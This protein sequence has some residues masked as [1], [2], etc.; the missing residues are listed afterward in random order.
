VAAQSK[1]SSEFVEKLATIN[2]PAIIRGEP[3]DQRATFAKGYDSSES[4]R[5]D[6]AVKEAIKR[7]EE[8]WLEL[9]DH[10]EDDRYCKTVGSDA[11]YPRNWS[12]GD[13][14]QHII[15]ETLSEPYY[16]HL[17]PATKEDFHRFRLPAVAQDKRKLR[18]WCLARKDRK[19]YELQIEM[20]DW[21]ITQFGA[22]DTDEEGELLIPAIKREIAT[23]K[24]TRKAVPCPAYW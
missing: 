20:C 1:P 12:V 7:S 6:K 10:L 21:A 8:L 18:E 16:R 3:G 5:V 22:S 23:L 14:C 19:L 11:G 4:E 24:K 9:A 2:K 17:Q 13:V 15:G